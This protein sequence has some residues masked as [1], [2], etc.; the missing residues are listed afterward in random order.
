MIKAFTSGVSELAKK[1]NV[2][3][4]YLYAVMSFETGGTFDPAQKNMAGS[5]ATGLIQFMP[6][7]AKGLGTSTTA[8]I[9]ND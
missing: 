7:T 8:A 6:D 4:D 5:G 3:E 2:P 1:Y 9:S